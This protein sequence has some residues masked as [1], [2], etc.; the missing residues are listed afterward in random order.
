T[1]TYSNIDEFV[2]NSLISLKNTNNFYE[3][4]NV[5]LVI[6]F[7][8][9]LFSFI[10]T[11]LDED[12]EN[13]NNNKKLYFEVAHYPIIAIYEGEFVNPFCFHNPKVLEISTIRVSIIEYEDNYVIEDNNANKDDKYAIEVDKEQE[14]YNR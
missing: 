10:T 6:S 9:E 1:I 8:I 12:K 11:I 14:I 3:N 5:K 7:D 2:Y 13:F 4:D